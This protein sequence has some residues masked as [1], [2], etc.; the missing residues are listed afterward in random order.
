M[1]SDPVS[2][3]SIFITYDSV[4][5]ITSIKQNRLD[6]LREIMTLDKSIT[7][8]NGKTYCKLGLITNPISH[9]VTDAYADMW[10]NQPFDVESIEINVSLTSNYGV[11]CS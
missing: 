10:P 9:V 11:E 1:C 3:Y 8:K 2:T 4:H 5:G 7:L 6:E